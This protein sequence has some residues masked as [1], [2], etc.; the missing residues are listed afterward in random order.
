MAWRAFG[1]WFLAAAF[2]LAGPFLSVPHAQ[3]NQPIY[4]AYDGYLKNPDG[5]YTLSFAYFSHNAEPVTIAPGPANS[6]AP[7]PADR[8]QPT[9]FR[10]GHQRFQCIIVVGREFDGNLRWTL[11]YAGTTTGTSQNML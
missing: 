11:T 3:R 9:T 6:F 5:S 8:Q 1:A 4:P 2:L 7:A 10:P